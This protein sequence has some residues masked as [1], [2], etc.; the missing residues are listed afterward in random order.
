MVFMP[1]GHAKSKYASWLFPAWYLSR[2]PGQMVIGASHTQSLAEYFSRKVMGELREHRPLLGHDFVT[3]NVAEWSLTNGG[4]YKAAGIGGHI[5]GRRSDLTIIDDPVPGQAEADS[6]A[7]RNKTWNWYQAE[8]ISRMLP[9]GR[10]VLIQTRW[11]EDDL[12]GRIL[13]NE[14]GWRVLKLPALAEDPALSTPERP[15]DPDP[16]GR[17]P[18]EALWPEMY[19]FGKLIKRQKVSGERVWSALYQQNP[20]PTAGLLFDPSKIMVVPK[21]QVPPLVTEGRGWDKAA[22]DVTISSPDPDY[23]VGAKMGRTAAGRFV[24]THIKRFR[25]RPEIVERELL[26]TS[27]A[28]GKQVRQSIPQDPNA[29]GK[30]QAEA[31]ARLLAGFNVLVSREGGNKATR[32]SPFASQVNAGNVSMVYDP[33]WNKTLIEELSMFPAGRKDDQVDALSRAF[34]LVSVVPTKV[35]SMRINF[36]AR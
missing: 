31:D 28:D 25:G 26:A 33:E 19:D 24:I 23:T 17:Q 7:E 34:E 22:T 29:A 32:A 18:G 30:S 4:E 12:G 6:E 2:R 20:T 3:E 35:R 27:T 8:V 9:G 15:I 36:L 10:I 16:L 1:P 5:T 21:D 11:H 14:E 13:E